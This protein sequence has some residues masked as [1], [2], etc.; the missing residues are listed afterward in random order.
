MIAPAALLENVRQAHIFF[1]RTAESILCW[2]ALFKMES[3]KSPVIH[4][5]VKA[6]REMSLP[7]VTYRFRRELPS[8]R[9]F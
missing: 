3:L 7:K 8:Q 6:N 4:F 9:S 5:Q 2:A 1:G